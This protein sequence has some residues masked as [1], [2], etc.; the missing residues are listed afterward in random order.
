MADPNQDKRNK[1]RED[2][3]CLDESFKL[4]KESLPLGRTAKDCDDLPLTPAAD[5]FVQPESCPA[6][7][8]DNV[9]FPD[10]LIVLSTELTIHCGDDTYDE[11]TAPNPSVGEDGYSVTVDAGDLEEVVS[12]SSVPNITGNQLSYIS[13]IS[14][15]LR[16]ELVAPDTTVT[17]IV[18][19]TGLSVV[20]GSA[21]K[22]LVTAAISSVNDKALEAALA[23]IACYYVNAEYI[24]YCQPAPPDAASA[25]TDGDDGTDDNT[26]SVPDEFTDIVDNP[27]VIAAGTFQSP[28]SQT[29]ADD[30]AESAAEQALR[31]VYCNDEQTR[32]CVDI[33]FT[34]E[35][36]TDVDDVEDSL[37][38]DKRKGSYT[39]AAY[40]VC[41][42][43]S[44]DEANQLAQ[45]LADSQLS[46][47]Y[48]NPEI[49]VDCSTIGAQ[50]G[51]PGVT[52][53]PYGN[54][55]LGIRG[56][57]ITVPSGYI[58]STVSTEDA[59]NQ[60]YAV[61]ISMLDCWICNDETILACPAE[62]VIANDGSTILVPDATAS[63]SVVN[64]CDV[65]AET[66][67]LA[68]TQALDLATT[69]LDC[70]YCNPTISSKCSGT[71]SIDETIVVEEGTFCCPGTGGAQTCY[72][73]AVSTSI[74]IIISNQGVDCRYCNT[75]QTA[76]CT[77]EGRPILTEGCEAV[78]GPLTVP[79]GIFCIGESAGGLSVANDLAY[80]MASAA[81]VCMYTNGAPIGEDGK[82]A[83]GTVVSF[84]CE[85]IEDTVD[86]YSGAN[87]ANGADGADGADGSPGGS[88]NCEGKCYG[89]Y[90]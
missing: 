61:A 13:T 28:V 80:T 65:Q 25:V 71:G 62:S 8:A 51:D 32:T 19:I 26:V 77:D 59:F 39:V 40:T 52:G 87:G 23:A 84:S 48:V 66:L 63:Y 72:E 83:P 6:P 89:F 33:G 90:S 17:R 21:F 45:D 47:F 14:N 24:L 53:P 15:E 86:G 85:K 76:T 75:E 68:N 60:A 49:T 57:V 41:S 58:I 70:T 73:I 56:Q 7:G 11:T 34:E 79:A 50:A 67:A 20:Q 30:L 16:D 3:S 35:V 69:L 5:P 29:I 64:Q 43:D 42:Y 44:K 81:L 54:F 18:E 2:P 37:A 55:L 27:S 12:F 82:V 88:G 74:P 46:C 9:T 4:A 78:G 31:C 38:G 1:L 10:P 36:I 22:D